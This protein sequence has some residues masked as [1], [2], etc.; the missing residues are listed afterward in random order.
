MKW[1]PFSES[2]ARFF[3]GDCRECAW[4]MKV[5]GRYRREAVENALVDFKGP[6]VKVVTEGANA[7][8]EDQ[9]RLA[10]RVN[11]IADQ[12]ED[13]IIA[14][15]REEERRQEE[16]DLKERLKKIAESEGGRVHYASDSGFTPHYSATQ[17]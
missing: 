9:S 4:Q 5:Q 2:A 6:Y 11:H 13:L 14:A 3:V 15:R 8:Y 10:A 17:C 1:I 7:A 16:H 12:V